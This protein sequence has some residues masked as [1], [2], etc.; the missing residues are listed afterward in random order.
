MS[1]RLIQTTRRCAQTR[2]GSVLSETS[3]LHHAPQDRNRLGSALNF[4]GQ[5]WSGIPTCP[6]FIQARATCRAW[7]RP[8]IAL[9]RTEGLS[10]FGHSTHVPQPSAAPAARS[11]PPRPAPSSYRPTASLR[12]P[13]AEPTWAN[14]LRSPPVAADPVMPALTVQTAAPATSPCRTSPGERRGSSALSAHALRAPAAP[15][16]PLRRKLCAMQSPRTAL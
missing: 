4:S 16:S 3:T 11:P 8:L 13:A 14:A 10:Q 1:P 7:S 2:T 5:V 12:R 6:P 15:K 9:A